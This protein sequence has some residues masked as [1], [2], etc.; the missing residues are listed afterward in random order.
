[1]RP[2]VRVGCVVR[3][4]KDWN[5]FRH[6]I[7]P[8]LSEQTIT[9]SSSHNG[10]KGICVMMI[11]YDGSAI[12]QPSHYTLSHSRRPIALTAA[13][14]DE[15]II[16][17]VMWRK[18]KKSARQRKYRFF[19]PPLHFAPIN[20]WNFP[21]NFPQSSFFLLHSAPL[22]QPKAARSGIKAACLFDCHGAE[23]GCGRIWKT[24]WIAFFI[25]TAKARVEIKYR[26]ICFQTADGCETTML[27]YRRAL[28]LDYDA[29]EIVNKAIDG[30]QL[31]YFLNS[32]LCNWD[33]LTFRPTLLHFD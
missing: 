6:I 16:I 23:R 30:T 20:R 21:I 2:D 1:M 22:Q 18:S 19:S 5:H 28:A 29:L 9:A 13:L 3:W 27:R 12:C 26:F 10:W 25:F 11:R 14:F 15:T 8:R 17:I 7:I 24:L 33:K 31:F 32:S 4:K